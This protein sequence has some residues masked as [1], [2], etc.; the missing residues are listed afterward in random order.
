[1]RKRKRKG[2]HPKRIW[3]WSDHHKK[4]WLFN[5]Y[6]VFLF[7]Y[8]YIYNFLFF[9]FIFIF[10]AIQRD[11][12]RLQIGYNVNVKNLTEGDPLSPSLFA[13][14]MEALSRMFLQRSVGGST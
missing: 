14:V 3:G 6:F 11:T 5:N 9:P 13:F 8:T 12:C 10:F 4:N 2:N 7:F 1:V